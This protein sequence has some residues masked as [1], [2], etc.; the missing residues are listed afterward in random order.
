[1]EYHYYLWWRRVARRV[2]LHR[3]PYMHMCAA[4]VRIVHVHV[5]AE[6]HRAPIC[7]RT[8]SPVAL[9]NAGSPDNEKLRF[10]N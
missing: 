5:P 6:A 1:M 2:A 10:L 7:G 4:G 3:A 9:E 8:L